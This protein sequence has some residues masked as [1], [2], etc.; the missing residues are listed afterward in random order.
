MHARTHARAC[1]G[2]ILTRYA[3][4]ARDAPRT[5]VTRAVHCYLQIPFST[6]FIMGAFTTVLMVIFLMRK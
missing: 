4:D 6:I 3:R 2:G 1:T 5:Q